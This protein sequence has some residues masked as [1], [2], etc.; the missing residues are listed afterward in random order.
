MLLRKDIQSKKQILRERYLIEKE[1][2]LFLKNGLDEEAILS[3]KQYKTKIDSERQ[4]FIKRKL[5]QQKLRDS[6]DYQREI[7]ELQNEIIRKLQFSQI[8][9]KEDNIDNWKHQYNEL[10]L[11][12]NRFRNRC[13]P[14]KD[15]LEREILQLQSALEFKIGLE[16]DK[17]QKLL[18]NVQKIQMQQKIDSKKK[19]ALEESERIL[20]KKQLEEELAK[21]KEFQKVENEKLRKRQQSFIEDLNFQVKEKERAK[22]EQSLKNFNDL[23]QQLVNIVN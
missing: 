10:E 16:N 12:R 21:F 6:S 13:L 20:Q 3:H 17:S 8:V 14:R 9:L 4:N 23:E 15:I 7:Y 22:V 2:V 5:H 11:L 18:Q 19:N 1:I